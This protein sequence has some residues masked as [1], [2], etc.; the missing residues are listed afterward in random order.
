[1]RK[2]VQLKKVPYHPEK[3]EMGIFEYDYSAKRFAEFA[4]FFDDFDKKRYVGENSHKDFIRLYL[5]FDDTQDGVWELKQM[6]LMYVKNK[7]GTYGL[8][9]FYTTEVTAQQISDIL[10][11]G[12]KCEVE[13]EMVSTAKEVET[14]TGKM[15]MPK[16]QP[17]M[18]DGKVIINILA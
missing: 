17:K 16:I 18:K 15:L 8:D 11:S 3:Y 4:G 2:A 6:P 13:M 7:L 5:V 14:V 10:S 12:G 9:D 1:M